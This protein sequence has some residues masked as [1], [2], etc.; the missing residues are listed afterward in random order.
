[1][2]IIRIKGFK[3]VVLTKPS[4]I[5]S[6]EFGK[7]TFDEIPKYIIVV[8]TDEG[9]TGIGETARGV[10][11]EN[12]IRIA[13][14]LIG[15]NPLKLS[16]GHLPVAE[17]K[18]TELN[19]ESKYGPRPWERGTEDN[20]VLEFSK[21]YEAFEIAIYDVIG[22]Y[23]ELPIYQLLGGA[24]RNKVLV[25]FWI[26]RMTPEEAAKKAREGKEK[27]F[28][29]L[30]MKCALEDPIV[31]RI[32]AITEAAG[33][34]FEIIV[35]PN[36]RF[37]RPAEA[38][39]LLKQLE[40]FKNVVMVEDP[41]PKKN[42]NWYVQLRQ[43][44]TIPVLMHLQ[45]DRDLI[46]AIKHEAIDYLNTCGNSMTAFLRM[47]NIADAAGIPCRHGSGLDLGILDMSYIHACAAAKNCI[48]PSGIQGH[49]IR[50]DDLIE[51][52][53]KF[54]GPYAIVP[55]RPGLGVNL[56][57]DALIKYTIEE[58]VLAE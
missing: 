43:K 54:E 8:E 52:K 35:D 48:L 2:K 25:N 9:I 37:Y 14:G 29:G 7:A 46:N 5:N 3:V 30:K 42:M 38:I 21:G 15:E 32:E 53:I 31:E 17:K 10:D 40:D 19:P 23:L 55:N 47:A 16:W 4:S 41:F 56:D 6:P 13:K 12:L 57:W 36:E 26:G 49:F 18:E 33:E 58:I 24:Y 51:E 45:D 28:R 34:D 11:E 27:G 20:F 22:K 1:M 44:T 50:E 39:K